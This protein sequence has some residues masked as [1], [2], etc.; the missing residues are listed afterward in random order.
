MTGND[1][2]FRRLIRFESIRIRNLLYV[3]IKNVHA[4]FKA[5]ERYRSRQV[6]F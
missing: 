4:Y 1:L 3:P 5:V 6:R 2:Y